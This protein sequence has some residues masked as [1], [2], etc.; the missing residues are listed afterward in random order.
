MHSDEGRRFGFCSIKQSDS[1]CQCVQIIAGFTS[2]IAKVFRN[3]QIELK[4]T[5]LR[6]YA[7][8][9]KRIANIY[10]QIRNM[11]TA[12][13]SITWRMQFLVVFKPSEFGWRVGFGF[14]CHIHVSVCVSIQNVGTLQPNWSHWTVCRTFY[15]VSFVSN[16]FRIK[17]LRW[18]INRM[19]RSLVPLQDFVSWNA[20]QV[21]SPSSLLETFLICKPSANCSYFPPNC[22]SLTVNNG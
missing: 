16:K 4:Q 18:T 12:E 11:V 19:V 5:S 20:L 15:M 6:I 9:G 1:S 21:Y 17:D 8:F 14:T 10:L 2:I 13:D 3:I 7:V 22:V